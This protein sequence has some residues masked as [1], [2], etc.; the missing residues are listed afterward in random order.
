MIKTTS[1]EETKDPTGNFKKT[2]TNAK[3]S[4]KKGVV[5]VSIIVLFVI[6]TIWAISSTN[7]GSNQINM[8]TRPSLSV[9]DEGIINNNDEINN[10]E[11]TVAL[12][13][14]EEAQDE[15]TKTSIAKDS[16]GF[17]E[18]I[19]E[20]KIFI[21][22]NCTKAKVIDSSMFKRRVRILEGEQAGKAGW[23][24]YEFITK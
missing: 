6:T 15:F 12:T 8:P 17:A 10:C 4:K 19:L 13:M 5:M 21:V 2:G 22:D 11:G 7:K 3:M 9:G 18:M 23:L 20:G 16:A 14:T 24:P 1:S